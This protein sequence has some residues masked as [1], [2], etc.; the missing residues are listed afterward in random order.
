MR[1]KG[2][3]IGISDVVADRGY[4]AADNLLF[5]ESKNIEHAIPLFQARIGKTEKGLV[6]TK[7]RMPT[8]ARRAKYC[9]AQARMINKPTIEH[10]N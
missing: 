3:G 8:V 2:R 4:G 1:L 7:R 9:A 6:I 5:L 10:Q